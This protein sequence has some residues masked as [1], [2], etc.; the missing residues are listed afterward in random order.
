MESKKEGLRNEVNETPTFF[1]NDRKYVG[2][3]ELEELVD[4]L[5]EE[6]ERVGQRSG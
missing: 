2:D 6:Y 1:I 3:L 5:E 4:V